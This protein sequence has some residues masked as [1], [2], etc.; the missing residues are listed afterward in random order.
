[1]RRHALAGHHVERRQELRAGALARR[2]QKM[3]KCLDGLEQRFGLLVALDYDK[4]RALG[5]LPQQY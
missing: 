4:Q 1:M 2:D 5:Y 3:E